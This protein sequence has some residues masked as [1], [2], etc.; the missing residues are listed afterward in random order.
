MLHPFH[1]AQ[2]HSV[3]VPL[4]NL[5]EGIFG[6]FTEPVYS[7]AVNKSWVLEDAVPVGKQPLLNIVRLLHCTANRNK[8]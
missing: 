8:G 4:S 1:W 7:G 6:P 2:L 5:Q 3:Q